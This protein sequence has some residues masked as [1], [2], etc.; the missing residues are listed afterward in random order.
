M[1]SGERKSP[2][3][4]LQDKKGF[5]ETVE[6]NGQQKAEDNCRHPRGKQPQPFSEDEIGQKDQGIRFKEQR[7]TPE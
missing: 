3:P 4:F 5:F 2:L 1:A 6:K 7:E